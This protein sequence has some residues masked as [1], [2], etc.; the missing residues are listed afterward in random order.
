MLFLLVLLVIFA[1]FL[2]RFGLLFWGWLFVVSACVYGCGLGI[3]FEVLLVL[4]RL[5]LLCLDC[6][7]F[8][9]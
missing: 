2:F 7:T 3:L 9:C 8:V 1:G 4:C 5:V 6:V